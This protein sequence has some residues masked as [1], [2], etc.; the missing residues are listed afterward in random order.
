MDGTE[1]TVGCVGLENYKKLEGFFFLFLL[2]LCKRTHQFQFS[3][4]FKSNAISRR[5]FA[6]IF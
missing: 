4:S 6:V 5:M 1:T 3:C 2:L